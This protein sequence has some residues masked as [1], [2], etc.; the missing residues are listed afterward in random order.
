VIQFLRYL[1]NNADKEAK[2]YFLHDFATR[3]VSENAVHDFIVA[4]MKCENDIQFESWL[5]QYGIQ[6]SFEKLRQKSLYEAVEIIINTFVK[7]QMSNAYIQ[8]FLD[9]VLE[10]DLSQQSGIIDFLNFWEQQSERFSVPSPEGNNAIK[11][12]TIHKSKGLEFPVVIFPFAEEDYNRAPKDRLWLDV[13][14][15]MINLSRGLVNHNIDLELYNDDSQKA[16]WQITQDTLLDNLNVLYVALTRA[17]EQLYIISSMKL[18]K[19]NTVVENNMTTFFIDFLIKKGQFDPNAFNYTFGNPVKISQSKKTSNDL[20]TIPF[21]KNTIDPKA[22]KI[23][24]RSALMWGSSAASKIAFGNVVHEIMAWIHYKE[25]YNIAIQK[26]LDSG[27]ISSQQLPEVAEKIN[28]VLAHPDL[29]VYFDIRHKV[30]NEQAILFKD[31]GILKPDRI[32]ENQDGDVYLLD[33]KTGQKNESHH[34]Q[35]NQYALALEQMQKRV[36]QKIIVYLGE[37]IAI[38]PVV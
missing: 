14:D 7:P 8:H 32:V 30:W 24:K 21:L 37:T 36:V 16:L 20:K 10:R 23:A 33:Y 38:V 5:T 26:A 31:R 13:P 28:W 27:L 1:K 25:D 3:F 17:A 29:D 6:I 2:S 22:I 11:I 12:L 35:L 4:G 9:I 19:D 34:A 18:K 15:E